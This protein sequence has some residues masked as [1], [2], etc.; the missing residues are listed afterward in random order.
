[1]QEKFSKMFMHWWLS[2][3]FQDDRRLWTIDRAIGLSESRT[4]SPKRVSGSQYGSSELVR[5]FKEASK[6]L[7]FLHNKNKK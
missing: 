3:N 7:K 4:R 2:D 1:M 5:D 6:K